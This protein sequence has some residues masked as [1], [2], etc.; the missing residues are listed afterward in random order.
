MCL[1]KE[2]KHLLIPE[3]LASSFPY[4]N[5]AKLNSRLFYGQYGIICLYYFPA[6]L[7]SIGYAI[8][9][10]EAIKFKARSKIEKLK[11]I[12]VNL[13]IPFGAQ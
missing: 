4:E 6:L 1:I 8:F 9:T 12:L 7:V 13:S 5:N 3:D 11:I 10:E 2:Q